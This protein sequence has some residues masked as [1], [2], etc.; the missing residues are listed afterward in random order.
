MNIIIR[1]LVSA[2]ALLFAAYVVP[3]I[4]VSNIYVAIIAAIILGLLNLIARPILIILTLPVTIVTLGL[5][6]FIIN[7][8]LFWFAASFVEGF[9]VRGFFPALIG[10]LVVSVVSSAAH[11]FIT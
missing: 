4:D 10:S 1:I 3:G 5:F 8:L 2:L 6:I 11:K 9:T 7:A